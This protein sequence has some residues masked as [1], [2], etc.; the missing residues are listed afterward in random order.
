MTTVLAATDNE[1]TSKRLRR[2]LQR[3][4]TDDDT[5]S[6]V[7]SQ[8]GGDETSDVDAAAGERAMEELAEGLPNTEN[9]QLV[10][11][12]DPATDVK[13]FATRHNVDGIVIGIHER[14]R[15]GKVIF[16]STAQDI[17]LGTE[18]P[19]VAVPTDT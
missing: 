9:H 4:V 8:R 15:T 14:S 17:L 2:Y 11:G 10:R 1:T 16:G 6:V 18:V 3:R 7:N 13:K 5:V 19:V 12:N